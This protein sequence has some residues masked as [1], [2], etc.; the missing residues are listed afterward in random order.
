MA[1]ECLSCSGEVN[2]LGCGLTEA[3]LSSLRKFSASLEIKKKETFILEGDPQDYYYQIFSGV[4][5]T[6]NHFPDGK[7]IITEILFAGDF[8]GPQPGDT[9][10]FTA[11]SLQTVFL[12]RFEKKK[13]DQ[14]IAASP[15]LKDK[16]NMFQQNAINKART[17]LLNISHKAP[18]ERVAS[19]LLFICSNIEPS[20]QNFLIPM[21]RQEIGD[22]LS[23]TSETVSRNMTDLSAQS[24]IAMETPSLVSICDPAQLYQLVYGDQAMHPHEFDRFQPKLSG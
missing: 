18:L 19:F 21:G 8:I 7:R 14:L 3:E 6:Y 24:I 12:C 15:N 16:I 13:M 17:H 20:G 10:P 2:Y 1:D 4:A 11:E 5:G 9:Y 23:L 22:Y